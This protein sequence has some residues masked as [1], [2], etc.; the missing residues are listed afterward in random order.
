ML[1]LVMLL[2]PLESPEKRWKLAPSTSSPK[3]ASGLLALPQEVLVVI[4]GLLNQYDALLL[5]RTCRQLL[6]VAK[7]R[8]CHDVVVDPEYLM[9]DNADE[10]GI[11]HTFIN[12][13]YSL[14]KFFHSDSARL[15]RH[16]KVTLPPDFNVWAH[17]DDMVNFFSDTKLSSIEWLGEGWLSHFSKGLSN[18]A[19]LKVLCK[20]LFPP[21]MIPTTLK[22]QSFQLTSNLRK[23]LA[24][25]NLAYCR[26][27]WLCRQNT[28]D[29]GT[30][31][32]NVDDL[33]V[34]LTAHHIV[35]KWYDIQLDTI[36]SLPPLPRL[37]SLSLE[38][39]VVVASDAHLLASTLPHL[40]R[41]RLLAVLECR[42]REGEADNVLFLT[43]IAPYLGNLKQLALDYRQPVIDSVPEFLRQMTHL[44]ALD[45][46][47][48][49][50]NTKTT[51]FDHYTLPDTLTKL[52]IEVKQEVSAPDATSVQV[53]VA[54]P[55]PLIKM[56]EKLTQLESLRGNFTPNLAKFTKLQLLDV[57]G[58]TTP[59]LAM[60]D[61]LLQL[62]H[63][64]LGYF[65]DQ[66]SLVYVRVNTE[67]FFRSRPRHG[68][69][70]WLDSQ[71]R[72]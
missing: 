54:M 4:A 60:F 21:P 32:P 36:A 16:L 34:T 55:S 1:T 14:E 59:G 40:T 56:I 9:F 70:R 29:N 12:S 7:L 18:T 3:V 64:V 42:L 25:I 58:T 49:T 19:Q 11:H 65:S 69:S 57:F 35:S 22:W 28:L 33:M 27:L 15:V 30:L 72:V 44:Q 50:N 17:H 23:H 46:T 26:D 61:T 37:T 52:A 6:K 45:L 24:H 47:I 68:L 71:V 66:P 41:L 2:S 31:F 38:D 62:H 43:L 5:G 10:L 48:R 67:V 53:T 13:G 39:V 8:I 63:R 51:Q 20:E